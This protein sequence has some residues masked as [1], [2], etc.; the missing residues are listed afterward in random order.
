MMYVSLKKNIKNYRLQKYRNGFVLPFTMLITSLILFV[1]LGTMTLISKQQLFEKNDRKSQTAYYVA[2]DAMAC[3]IKIDDSYVNSNG[4][5]IFPVS[6]S[7]NSVTVN[8][9]TTSYA[10][11]DDVI[12]NVNLERS[13]QVD[14]NGDPLQPISLL[15]IK[16]GESVI[17]DTTPTSDSKFTVATT[18]DYRHYYINPNTGLEEIEYGQT[19]IFSIR[20]LVGTNEYRCATVTVNKTESYREIIS[21]GYSSCDPN[22]QRVERAIV[23]S[24]SI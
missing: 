4:T 12:A 21:Q 19:S 24:T 8:G 10:Y 7:T 3:A 13:L 9:A 2:D 11:I 18:T 5:G 15:D 20:M 16:C 6:S 23:N 22:S 17:F 1:M 14:A